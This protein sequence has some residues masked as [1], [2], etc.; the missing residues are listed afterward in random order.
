MGPHYAVWSPDDV[1]YVV[2]RPDKDGYL[3]GNMFND[4]DTIIKGFSTFLAS[5]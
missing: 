1:D 3:G 5:F 2:W 4:L